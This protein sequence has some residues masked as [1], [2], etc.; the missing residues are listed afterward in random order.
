MAAPLHEAAASSACWL[1]PTGV[2]DVSTFDTE[3]AKL[4]QALAG[5][6]SVAL[7]NNAL[8]ERVRSAAEQTEHLSLHDP[9]TGL[10]NRLH[11]HQRLERRLE[12]TGS[13][14]VLL[15]DL[16]RFKEVNDTL[17]HDV[18]DQLLR[19]VASAAAWP[20]SSD[21]TVVARIGGDEFAVM[22]TGDEVHVEGMV[23][24][25]TRDFSRPIR[26]DDI[27]LDV[28][29]QHRHRRRATGRVVRSAAAAPRRGR[30]VRRQA[31]ARRRR[32]LRIRPRPLQR[33]AAVPDQRPR[34]RARGRPASSCTTSRR[35][36]RTPA[37]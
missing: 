29:R 22:L 21:E 28:M 10:P 34:P 9:L 23:Q 17:G 5:H 4:L 13:A 11:F 31:R 36:S 37:A 33:A 24:R 27:E 12:A 2:D 8:V 15:M 1:S 30:D 14:A 19:Q 6:A 16:D 35:P 25:I 26:L 20:S 32:A 3:D 7:A 18:G